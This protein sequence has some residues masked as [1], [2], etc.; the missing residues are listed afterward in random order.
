MFFSLFATQQPSKVRRFFVGLRRGPIF[1]RMC[2]AMWVR[3]WDFNHVVLS[4]W[5]WATPRFPYNSL[6]RLRKSRRFRILLVIRMLRLRA[7]NPG[8]IHSGGWHIKFAIIAKL[9][10]GSMPISSITS[11]RHSRKF[12]RGWGGAG[13][14][15]ALPRRRRGI[16]VHAVFGAQQV[17]DNSPAWRPTGR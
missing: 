8:W 15:L 13:A 2:R 17:G 7:V 12:P 9:Q 3:H 10:I 14:R 11:A 4:T 6:R 1:G 16:C 5:T